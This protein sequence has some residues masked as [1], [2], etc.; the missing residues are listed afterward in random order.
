M[1]NMALYIKY[2]REY[3]YLPEAVADSAKELARKTGT[4]RSAVYS[5]ISH[6]QSTYAVIKDEEDEISSAAAL[7]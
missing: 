7:I 5:A 2:S 6:G 1:N 3:P 4:S